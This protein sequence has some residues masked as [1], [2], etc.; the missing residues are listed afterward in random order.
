MY[1]LQ[2]FASISYYIALSN[3]KTVEFAVHLP[4]QKGWFN[5]K[6]LI[7]SATGSVKLTIPIHGGRN[8]NVLFRDVKI[9]YDQNWRRQHIRTIETCYGN[10]PFFE[11]Y[12]SKFENLFQNKFIFL[13]DLNIAAFELVNSIL[14]LAL[15]YKLSD[16]SHHEIDVLFSKFYCRKNTCI[17][18]LNLKYE[19]VFENKN[20][21]IQNLSII[22]LIFCTGPHANQLLNNTFTA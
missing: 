6:C 1:D 9:A 20:G 11:H 22:D 12:F 17:H 18:T 3:S 13:V 2:L 8:Q 19:Q 21:F 14:Q 15:N 16:N 7:A 10:A 4:Y 5:N